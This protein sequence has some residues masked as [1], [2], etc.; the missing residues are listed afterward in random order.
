MGPRR[1]VSRPACLTRYSAEARHGE[2]LTPPGPASQERPIL[3]SMPDENPR[4]LRLADASAR[5]PDLPWILLAG[6]PLGKL[7]E[8]LVRLGLGDPKASRRRFYAGSAHPEFLPCSR[9]PAG[10]FLDLV[11]AWRHHHAPTDERLG[12]IVDATRRA[13]AILLEAGPVDDPLRGLVS[14][15][16][17]SG[18]E[19][20]VLLVPPK[21][22][23]AAA[24][25][26]LNTAGFKGRVAEAAQWTDELR[27]PARTPA[28]PAAAAA[29]KTTWFG[30]EKATYAIW[31][32]QPLRLAPGNRVDVFE[33]AQ[34][35]SGTLR[36]AAF[37]KVVVEAP[38]KKTDDVLG[39]AAPGAAL[40]ATLVHATWVGGVKP[41]DGDLFSLGRRWGAAHVSYTGGRF[42]V[43]APRPFLVSPGGLALILQDDR[44]SVLRLP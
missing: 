39:L 19:R 23:A 35:R 16:R 29:L 5:H 33:G 37:D 11:A 18:V 26:L 27:G 10:V 9:V 6:D 21:K 14:L 3:S 15:A 31:T 8:K 32:G 20:A 28:G 43:S 42:V 22:D 38:V 30:L 34:V 40:A 17:A 41:A 24:R 36:E 25:E 4:A 7:R 1:E 2:K 12:P 13:S 44:M